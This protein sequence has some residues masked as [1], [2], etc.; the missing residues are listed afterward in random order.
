RA[1]GRLGDRFVVVN[2]RHIMRFPSLALVRRC[3]LV[4]LPLIVF[5]I[6]CSYSTSPHSD[7]NGAASVELVPATAWLT[8]GSSL[9]LTAIGRDAGG[10]IVSSAD[11]TFQ[12][13]VAG[14]ASVGADGTIHANSAG[15]V[16]ITVTLN[17]HRASTDVVV[18]PTAIP[19][20]TFAIE[21]QGIS[22]VSLLGAWA[23]TVTDHAF[24]VGQAGIVM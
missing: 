19:S 10:A 8:P 13:T 2:L 14:V 15:S 24:A 1:P 16:R 17:G 22:D 11:A 21:K 9:A 18:Q 5:L 7:P 20:P 23:D 4:A 6:S 3:P 12:S